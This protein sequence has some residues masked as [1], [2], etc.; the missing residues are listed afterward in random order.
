MFVNFYTALM[1]VRKQAHLN[2]W[3]MQS[4]WLVLLESPKSHF[5]IYLDPGLII[6]LIFKLYIIILKQILTVFTWYCYAEL[7]YYKSHIVNIKIT[8][9]CFI[10]FDRNL[11]GLTQ[12]R[13]TYDTLSDYPKSK[14]KQIALGYI[15]RTLVPFCKCFFMF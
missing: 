1:Y 6:T 13:L 8:L 10:P 2:T 11:T 12:Y 4:L 15:K 5:I 3:Q 7:D 14:A 9:G